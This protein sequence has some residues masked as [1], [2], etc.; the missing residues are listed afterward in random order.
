MAKRMIVMLVL[1]GVV[2]A[3]IFGFEA[4]RATMIKRFIATQTAPVQTVSAS[5]AVASDWQAR[6]TAIGSLRAVRGADLS[7]QVGGIVA[8][9][10]FDSRRRSAGGRRA[11]RVAAGRRPREARLAR[12]KRRAGADHLRARLSASFRRRPSASKPSTPT[13]RTRKPP[14]RRSP[15]SRRPSITRP[16]A[17][18]S[19]ASSASARSMSANILRRAP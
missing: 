15:S 8:A 10:H 14:T 4:F 19:R 1:T 16:S 13:S 18:P 9:I 11:A 17:R 3:G 2:L 6:L 12:S 7:A 5:P